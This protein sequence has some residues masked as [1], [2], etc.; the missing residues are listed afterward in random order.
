MNLAS[1]DSPQLLELATKVN[2]YSNNFMAEQLLRA[3]GA[4]ASEGVGNWSSGEKPL[5]FAQ[6]F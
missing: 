2:H 6:Q 3:L 1:F 5:S 4:K